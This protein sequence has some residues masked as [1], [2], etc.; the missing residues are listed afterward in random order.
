MKISSFLYLHLSNIKVSRADIC[1]GKK[2]LIYN[3]E[4][5]NCLYILH[6]IASI[7]KGTNEIN[8]LN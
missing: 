3:L 7:V 4:L 1:S 8:N 2:T 6:Q 5:C